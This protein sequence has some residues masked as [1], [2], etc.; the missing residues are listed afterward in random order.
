[1]SDFI[2]TVH[3]VQEVGLM[4]TADPNVCAELV[5]P[6]RLHPRVENGNA[7]MFYTVNRLI[8]KGFVFREV[9]LVVG[10]N[11]AE[12]AVSQGKSEEIAF[13]H[14]AI[15]TSRWMS[16]ME[17]LFFS[18][19]Y[20][21]GLA[22]LTMSEP[23]GFEVEHNDGT[24]VRAKFS[25]DELNDVESSQL[26]DHW[27]GKVY[28]PPSPRKARQYMRARLTGTMLKVPFD[29]T[30]DEWTISMSE[31]SSI[32]ELMKRASFQPTQ[33]RIRSKGVHSR[34]KTYSEPIHR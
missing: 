15:N 31:N 9:T 5:A 3:D 6:L 19:P 13:L 23:T 32:G 2:A 18:T 29:P 12:N 8:W 17:R 27:E 16:F 11:P 4:G 26:E 10:L 30:Q 14:S 20:R 7:T 33:W 22:R 1:M 34:S 21:G 25:R 28:L 24:S